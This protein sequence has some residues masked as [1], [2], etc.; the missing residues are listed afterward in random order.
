MNFTLLIP[1]K[2][3]HSVRQPRN[4]LNK[5]RFMRSIK[6]LHVSVGRCQP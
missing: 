6:L 5:I 3:L 2:F 1:R 4:A